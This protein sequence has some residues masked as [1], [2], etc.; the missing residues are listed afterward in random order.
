MHNAMHRGQ[1]CPNV[2]W[3]DLA[4]SPDGLENVTDFVCSL[5]SLVS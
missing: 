5:L 3:F 2:M 1:R 4:C